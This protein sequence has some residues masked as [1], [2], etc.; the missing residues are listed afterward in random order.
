MANE[1]PVSRFANLEL[2]EAQVPA[3]LQGEELKGESYYLTEAETA[4]ENGRFEKAL[5]DFA[6]VLEYNPNKAG[7]WAGQVRMLIELGEFREAKLWA[8][9]ALERFPR[10]PE[11]LA[12]KA[13]ALARTGD[14]RGAMAF[15]DASFEEKGDTPYIWLAR[16]DVMLARKERNAAY[17]FDR[18]H[19]MA[20]N[21]WLIHWLASRIQYYY[22]KFSMALQLAQQA[23]AAD[24]TR[25]VVWL[26]VGLCQKELGMLALA[27]GSFEHA[28]DL[29]P[30]CRPARLWLNKI[31]TVS[32]ARVLQGFWRRIFLR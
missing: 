32:W 24:S 10:L 15:S 14:L 28:L 26:Q 29:D 17:C 2:T 7:A 23:L 25:G 12:A 6:K 16:A 21:D 20:P 19:T 4:F 13:V 8:D 27:Q 3:R 31:Q 30:A 11:L 18:A 22:H 1:K 5:R 9:K